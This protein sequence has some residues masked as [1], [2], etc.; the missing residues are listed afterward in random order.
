MMIQ[1]QLCDS[2]TTIVFL[3]ICILSVLFKSYFLPI[4]IPSSS[5]VPH[6]FS[7]SIMSDSLK[8]HGLQHTRPTFP[9]PT[10]GVYSNSCP[11][12]Q[13]HHPTISSSVDPF[14]SCLQSFPAS[15]SF[16]MSRFFT[17]GGQSIGISASTSVLPMNIQDW[18]PL[19]WTGWIS[20]KSEGLS[21]VFSNTIV[22]KYQFFRVQF[23]LWYNFHILTWLLEKQ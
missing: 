11:L 5:T 22:Q 16:L 17:S 3:F 23:S 12:S 19:R 13:W 9:P 1:I 10:P 18:F 7:C 20:L 14:T 6:F 8:P 4:N 21:R 15:G 2:L